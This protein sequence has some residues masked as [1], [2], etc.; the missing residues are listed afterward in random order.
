VVQ[1]RSLALPRERRQRLEDFVREQAA[2]VLRQ[3]P[4][5]IDSHTPF[6]SLG[7][8]SLMGLE[9]KNILE[10]HLELV[11]PVALVW[12]YPTVAEMA[13]YLAAQLGLA[14]EDEAEVATPATAPE[15]RRAA[16]IADL[17]DAEVLKMLEEK[18]GALQH[19]GE[20]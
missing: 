3:P 13:A 19:R 16:E 18:L 7:F 15:E 1:L 11:L 10:R 4:A 2:R 8:D 6:G 9:L 20:V 17:S 5:Q 12:N 14:L